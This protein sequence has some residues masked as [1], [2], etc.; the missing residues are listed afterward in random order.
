[1]PVCDMKATLLQLLHHPAWQ[2][3]KFLIV[4][5]GLPG[6]EHLQA[7]ANGEIGAYQEHRIGE[8]PVLRVGQLVEH[9]VGDDHAHAGDRS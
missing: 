5:A 8:S 2:Q 1:M 6:E 7:F 3:V 9:L 4:V